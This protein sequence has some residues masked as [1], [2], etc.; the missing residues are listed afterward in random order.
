MKKLLFV[1]D[2]FNAALNPELK[3]MFTGAT[4]LDGSEVDES[5]LEDGNIVVSENL[6]EFAGQIDTD[7]LDSFDNEIGIREINEDEFFEKIGGENS[8]TECRYDVSEV[9]EKLKT[10]GNCKFYSMSIE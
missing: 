10:L 4:Y 9:E 6:D 5:N 7:V 8:W 2:G 1:T 3:T